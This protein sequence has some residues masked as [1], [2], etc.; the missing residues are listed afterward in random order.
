[1]TASELREIRESRG[2]S[3]VK[4]AEMLNYTVSTVSRWETGLIKIGDKVSGNIMRA[5]REFD[6]SKKSDKK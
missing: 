1:M 3:Q 2:I 4:M 6:A 5:M